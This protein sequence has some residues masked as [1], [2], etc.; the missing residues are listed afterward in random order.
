MTVRDGRDVENEIDDVTKSKILGLD[1][2]EE[3]EFVDHN[4]NNGP[5]MNSPGRSRSGSI[6]KMGRKQSLRD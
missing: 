1:A 6:D 3:E 5:A 2:P 4:K